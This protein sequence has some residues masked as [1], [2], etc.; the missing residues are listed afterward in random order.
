MD[1]L[2]EEQ[3]VSLGLACRR[4]GF[5]PEVTAALAFGSTVGTIDLIAPG[6]AWQ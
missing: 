4:F 1:R 2:K 5:L 6:Q 3:E